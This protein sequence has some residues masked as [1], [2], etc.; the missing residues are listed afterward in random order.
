M[1]L[2][3]K[4][5]TSNSRFWINRFRIFLLGLLLALTSK[6]HTPMT[7]HGAGLCSSFSGRWAAVRSPLGLWW[8]L[9]P[10]L[11]L[12]LR[13]ARLLD[14]VGCGRGV[15]LEPDC[16]CGPGWGFLTISFMCWACDSRG[17]S[18]SPP[19]CDPWLAV[20]T[21]IFDMLDSGCAAAKFLGPPPEAMMPDADLTP[22]MLL[23]SLPFA[24][25]AE[26]GT[27]RADA[28]LYRELMLMRWAT[29]PSEMEERALRRA[30]SAGPR[31]E[32]ASV[33]VAA[34]SRGVPGS[35]GS[36]VSMA[37]SRGEYGGGVSWEVSSVDSLPNGS[38]GGW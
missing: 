1:T 6:A 24:E 31:Y 35:L 27:P 2:S 9:A 17:A 16:C 10:V 11:V 37:K 33:P 29:G 23:V 26:L 3:P 38:G 25:A 36:V 13:V 8:L 18:W 30:V 4:T 21:V 7:P 22:V 19:P 15:V 12:N 5:Q 14:L 28:R 32:V 34:W 20:V